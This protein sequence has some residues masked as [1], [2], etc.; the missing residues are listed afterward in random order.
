VTTNQLRLGDGFVSAEHLGT[1]VRAPKTA[2][3]IS[4]HLR[5]QIVRG[6]LKPRDALPSEAELMGQFGVSRPTLREAFRILET[7]NLITVRRGA[8]GGAQVTAPDVS[9]AA[10]YVGVLLQIEGTTI[11]DVSI[12]RMV[13]E[14]ACAGLLAR[15]RTADDLADL[16]AVVAELLAAT[17]SGGVPDS[18]RW[19]RL[20]YRF[21]EIVVERC[22]NKTLAIQVAVLQDIVA[23]HLETTI[24]RE[25]PEPSRA[26]RFRRMV[27]SYTKLIELLEARDADGAERHWRAH[28]EAAAKSMSRMVPLDRQVVD[29]FS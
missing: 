25:T 26:G 14:P 5:R 18:A 1:S 27:R 23:T 15:S 29:L 10:R 4:S 9:V 12:A 22:G 17:G 8:R 7:E 20:S 24:S 21:H 6:D 11:E 2:E 19:T 28:L 13:T 3:L 16:R